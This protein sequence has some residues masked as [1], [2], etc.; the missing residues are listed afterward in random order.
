MKSTFTI[1]DGVLVDVTDFAKRVG[2]SCPVAVTSA[3]WNE[4]L[5]PS[6][7]LQD[8]QN[9][10]VRLIDLLSKLRESAT[11]DEV[12]SE[13]SFSLLYQ[14]SDRVLANVFFLARHH[15]GEKGQPVIVI[16][17]SGEE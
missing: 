3:V 9:V 2:F 6:A 5:I 4:V 16:M 14:M 12:G 7:E 8:T 11:F 1:E 15:L 17:V 13:L 10:T